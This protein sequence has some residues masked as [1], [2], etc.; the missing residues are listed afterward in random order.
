MKLWNKIKQRFRKMQER[1]ARREVL[2]FLFEAGS[3]RMYFPEDLERGKDRL[4]YKQNLTATYTYQEGDDLLAK[5]Q[6]FIDQ[7]TINEQEQ[8]DYFVKNNPFGNPGKIRTRAWRNHEQIERHEA[9]KN[10]C[11]VVHRNTRA[12]MCQ[13]FMNQTTR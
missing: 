10:W 2:E 4:A 11:K 3:F 8:F 12:H 13:K 5:K 7:Y 1:S 6:D 9:Q